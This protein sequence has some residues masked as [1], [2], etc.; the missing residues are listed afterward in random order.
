MA[1]AAVRERI[2]SHHWSSER[3]EASSISSYTRTGAPDGTGPTAGEAAVLRVMAGASA[4]EQGSEVDT[5]VMAMG[6]QLDSAGA[7]RP[8]AYTR[9]LSLPGCG[10]R[11]PVKPPRS[12]RRRPAPNASQ[13]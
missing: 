3:Y 1:S 7:R 9:A 8:G 11:Y 13:V 6:I 5:L 2:P 4:P 10:S 12:R